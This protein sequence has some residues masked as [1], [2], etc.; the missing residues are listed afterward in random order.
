ML[1]G[2]PGQPVSRLYRITNVEHSPRFYVMDS[3]EQLKA[4]LDIDARDLEM[5]AMYHS[6]PATEPRP[7]KTD[8]ELAKWPGAGYLI[9]SLADPKNPELRLWTIEGGAVAESGLQI[10]D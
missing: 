2:R 8:I 5:A 10:A 7:S 1:A 4:L 3:Q 9:V 6:H